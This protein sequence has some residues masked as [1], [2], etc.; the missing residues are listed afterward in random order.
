MV[1]GRYYPSIL[2]LGLAVPHR[3][4]SPFHQRH[5]LFLGM[6]QRGVHFEN[7]WGGQLV[8]V[9]HFC[10]VLQP[11]RPCLTGQSPFSRI[12]GLWYNQLKMMA[13]FTVLFGDW[14]QLLTGERLDRFYLFGRLKHLLEYKSVYEWTAEVTTTSRTR[15]RQNKKWHHNTGK[16]YHSWKCIFK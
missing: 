9:V 2:L 5:R 13:A 8:L 12:T 6:V 3:S 11:G 14:Q 4:Q 16:F 15:E 10:K 1:S 7:L